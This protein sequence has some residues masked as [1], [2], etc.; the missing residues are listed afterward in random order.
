MKLV[1]LTPHTVNL[2]GLALPSEGL[3]RVSEVATEVSRMHTAG[4]API[5]VYSVSYGAVTGLPEP[6]EGTVYIVSRLIRTA[7]PE[8]GDLASPYGL[9]RDAEGRAIGAEGLVR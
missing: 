3:A 8:R 9:V 2:P 6:V 4:P 1:N 5:P 7:L